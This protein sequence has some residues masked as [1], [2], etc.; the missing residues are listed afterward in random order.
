[1]SLKRFGLYAVLASFACAVAQFLALTG[2]VPTTGFEEPLAGVLL[3]V[4][5]GLLIFAFIRHG[6]RAL[7]LLLTTLIIIAVPVLVIAVLL[8]CDAMGACF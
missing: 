4:W 2:M 1:M 7:P 8:Q 3:L 5:L 6:R